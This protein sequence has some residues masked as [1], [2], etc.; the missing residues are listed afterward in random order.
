MTHPTKGASPA[1]TFS[2]HR[3]DATRND[4][5]GPGNYSPGKRDKQSGGA[6]GR[7]TR[8]EKNRHDSPGPGAYHDAV[9]KHEGPQYSIRAKTGHQGS[10][11]N[12]PGPGNYNPFDGKFAKDAAYTMAGKTAAK[13]GD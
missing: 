13:Y 12:N 11:M 10:R 5:P 4:C 9:G 7:S 1:W 3:T 6:F 8:D 2:G